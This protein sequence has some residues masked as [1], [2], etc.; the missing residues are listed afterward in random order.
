M[1]ASK[2]AGKWK[3]TPRAMRLF[4]QMPAYRDP[5]LSTT[6]RELYACADHPSEIRT[7]VLWQRGEESLDPD[8]LALANLEIV[9]TPYVDSKGSNWARSRLQQAWDGE[10]YT[11]FLDSH[12]RFSRGWDTSALEMYESCRRKSEKPILTG[13]LPAYDPQTDPAGWKNEPT[14]LY[15]HEREDGVLV[16]VTSY[17]IP[18]WES[19]PEPVHGVFVSLHFLFAEGSLNADIQLDP[20]IYYLRDEVVT[21]V[22]AFTWG[23]DVYHP[24]RVIGWHC[25][26]RRSRVPHWV[27]RSDWYLNQDATLYKM[28]RHFT[29]QSSAP[30]GYYGI[31][32]TV[33]DFERL[34]M[35][36]LVNT[37]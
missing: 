35:I 25:Y 16:R 31:A 18:F 36:P 12:H 37:Q 14:K 5:E 29:D 24:H 6:L 34:A 10:P 27:E 7:R 11:L 8:V 19:E 4:V 20:D 22:Q 9:E 32:R 23:Y 3:P 33:R 1:P 15:P 17:P 2:S 13:Y 30:A 21:S 28:R 26:D